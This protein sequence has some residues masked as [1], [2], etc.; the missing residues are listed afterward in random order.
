M[1]RKKTDSVS[2]A[3]TENRRT[4]WKG[5][6]VQEEQEKH[7]KERLINQAETFEF[8]K[9]MDKLPKG[10]NCIIWIWN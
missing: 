8:N 1:R 5:Q 4:K 10:D 7:G 2:E 3:K 6:E 9:W